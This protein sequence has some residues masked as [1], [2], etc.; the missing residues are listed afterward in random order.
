LELVELLTPLMSLSTMVLSLSW[1]APWASLPSSAYFAS[2]YHTGLTGLI[3]LMAATIAFLMVWVEY[4]VIAETSAL[5]F[6]IAGTCKE[7]VTGK[8]WLKWLIMYYS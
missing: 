1:E 7:V 8:Q 4:K 5:T 6:M 3:V 2:L